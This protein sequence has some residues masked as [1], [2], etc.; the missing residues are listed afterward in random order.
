[1]RSPSDDAMSILF[2]GGFI[3]LVVAVGYSKS[4]LVLLGGIAALFGAIYLLARK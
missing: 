1:M 4:L 2:I 3:A